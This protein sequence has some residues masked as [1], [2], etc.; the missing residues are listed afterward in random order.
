MEMTIEVDG[1]EFTIGERVFDGDICDLHECTYEAE[2]VLPEDATA[3]DRIRL[4]GEV[5]G[6]AL[7]KVSRSRTDNDL[8]EH[9]A[10]IV[11][12]IYPPDM[13]DEKFFRYLP[14]LIGST[15]VDGRA[16]NIFP[17]FQG[18]VS[19]ADILVAYPK[20]IDFRDMV[21]M[22]KRALAG[23]GFV[24]SDVIHGALIPPHILVHP[25]EHGAKI[26]DWC[27]AIQNNRHPVK[28][29][30][31]AFEDYYAPEI[32]QKRRATTFTDTAMITKCA[33][34]LVG[35]DPTTGDMPDTVPDEIQAFLKREAFASGT[36]SSWDMHEEFDKVLK[37]VI[38]KPKY[39]EFKMPEG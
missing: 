11:R 30:V 9:E 25:T 16:A 38:G 29:M 23:I 10:N 17:R 26:I 27:Y 21:W 35:G 14:R 19:L 6:Q 31:P 37:R 28:A 5:G 20:G 39:R 33:I 15:V 22:Y 7:L 18:Y 4:E 32:L 13:A 1:T 36:L 3:W 8:V 24:H 2:A 12:A 34:G